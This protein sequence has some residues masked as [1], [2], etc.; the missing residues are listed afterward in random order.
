M[1]W[2]HLSFRLRACSV[3]AVG[4]MAVPYIEDKGGGGG[5]LTSIFTP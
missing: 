4:A 1:V 3:Q 5:N 2:A